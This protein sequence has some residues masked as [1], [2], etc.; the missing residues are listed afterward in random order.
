MEFIKLFGDFDL[1]MGQKVVTAL[2][3]HSEEGCKRVTILIDSN[4][5]RADVLQNIIDA[6]ED[7]R[8]TRMKVDTFNVEKAYSCGAILLSFGDRGFQAPTC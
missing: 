8:K 5:G 2:Y 1:D 7:V 4:G 3:K 6:I